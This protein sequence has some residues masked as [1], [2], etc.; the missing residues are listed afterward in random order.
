MPDDVRP[1]MTQAERDRLL[2]ETRDDVRQLKVMLTGNGSPEKGVLWRL[3][4]VE[5]YQSDA[6]KVRRWVT[7]AIVTPMLTGVGLNIWAAVRAG[8]HI[9]EA[10]AAE[11]REAS[12]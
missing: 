3:K 6:R 9:G 2:R 8:W 10:R 5:D 12:P 7:V 4:A 1:T 11:V